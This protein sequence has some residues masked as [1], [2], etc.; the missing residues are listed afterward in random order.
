M[1]KCTFQIAPA[2]IAQID[3]LVQLEEIS[4]PMDRLSRRSMRRFIS[5]DQS[6]FLIAYDTGAPIGYLIIVF[7]RGTRLARLYSLATE[8]AWRGRG[9]AKALLK[10]GEV[11]ALRRGAI[12][13][14][15]EVGNT[16][17]SAIALFQALGFREFGLLRDYYDDHSDALRMQKRIR[18]LTQNSVH[19]DI[20][21]FLQHT[22]FTCGPVA[23]M[24]AMAGLSAGY[25]PSLNEELQLWRETTTI[26]MTSGHGGCHPLGL[27]LAARRRNF[28]AEVWLNKRG[29]L[30]IEGVRSEEKK[31]IVQTVH[32]D[33]VNQVKGT[34]IKIH[35]KAIDQNTLRS[36][37][38][39]GAIPIVLISTYRFDRKKVPHWVVFSGYD[40]HCFYVHDPDFDEKTQTMLDLQY[41]P[42][43][44]EDFES[45][46]SFGS[47]RLRS[48]IILSAKRS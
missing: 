42:I 12:H 31:N 13:F 22:P 39:G 11:E 8:P 17:Q 40:E 14:R 6:I 48:A 21:W 16:N 45:M 29:P 43:A 15:L 35:Y 30:F 18:H 24:M 46:S 7:H 26:F 47:S 2:T 27:A 38:D 5:N 25:N 23:M 33:F 3:W 36:A 1:N 20:P 44:I 10:A 41:V 32:D 37:C 9:V 28:H 19:A 4:F 34:D